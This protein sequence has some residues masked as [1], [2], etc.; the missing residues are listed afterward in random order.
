MQITNNKIDY[1]PINKPFISPKEL[2]KYINISVGTLAVWRTNRT[3]DLPYVKIGGRIMYPAQ[4]VNE[5]LA[6]R[7][8]NLSAQR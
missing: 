5:W 6:I 7:F 2:S 1:I 4:Q 8:C 3:Y